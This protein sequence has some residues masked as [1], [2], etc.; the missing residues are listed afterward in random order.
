MFLW[1]YFVQQARRDI[2][3][4]H[5]RQWTPPPSETF[6]DEL[7]EK[8][9]GMFAVTQKPQPAKNWHSFCTWSINELILSS[10]FNRSC[11][12]CARLLWCRHQGCLFRGCSVCAAASL[13][14][15]LCLVTEACAWCQLY[16]YHKQRF[17]VCHV[18][19]GACCSEV[20]TNTH[21]EVQCCKV[22][23]LFIFLGFVVSDASLNMM[24][25]VIFRAVVS[26]AKALIP[27]I[28]PL[29]SAALQSIL[30]NVIRVFPHAEQ[31]LKKKK[32]Q[33]VAF[34]Y[35]ILVHSFTD[36]GKNP[37]HLFSFLESGIRSNGCTKCW[38][39]YVHSQMW[40][41]VCLKT[42]WCSVRMKMR[43]R[44]STPADRQ[45][46][47]NLKHKLQRGSSTSAGW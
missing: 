16:H 40:L 34:L 24:L 45:K 33:G 2:L 28:R 47:P 22:S 20:E 6:L 12:L 23:L 13:P 4:I 25:F 41:V 32:D 7:A 9:V 5:T 29:L 17:H 35:F 46:S 18:K 1:L 43:M 15:N 37:D 30:H 36:R 10:R 8:C 11:S 14:T 31:G 38:C 21:C 42:S 19:D 3:K 26:P 39:W 44:R 27:A